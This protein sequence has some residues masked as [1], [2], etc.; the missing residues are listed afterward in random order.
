MTVVQGNNQAAI[1]GTVLPMALMVRVTDAFGNLLEG[2]TVRWSEV[3]GGGQLSASAT[4]TNQVGQTQVSYRVPG[5]PG[6]YN[7]VADIQGTPLTVL[8]TVSA[9][10]AP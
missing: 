8:F 1:V 6:S 7:V 5:T 4:T 9:L 10:P 3:Q 2:I